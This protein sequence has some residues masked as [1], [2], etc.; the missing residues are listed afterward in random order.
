MQLNLVKESARL[1][2]APGNK[3]LRYLRFRAAREKRSPFFLP[4]RF[5]APVTPRGRGQP[6]VA[7]AY[8]GCEPRC[9]CACE[10]LISARFAS[11]GCISQ[12]RRSFHRKPEFCASPSGARGIR[13]SPNPTN[14]NEDAPRS[15]LITRARPL[16]RNLPRSTSEELRIELSG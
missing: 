15:R 11:R 6:S 9:A 10:R 4:R 14:L 3:P 1:A 12:V 7:G 5:S 8:R 16:A 13:I 2:C